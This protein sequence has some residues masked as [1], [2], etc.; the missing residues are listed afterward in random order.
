MLDLLH[1]YFDKEKAAIKAL[2]DYPMMQAVL[3]SAPQALRETATRQLKQATPHTNQ[4]TRTT[5]TIPDPTGNQ[6]AKMIDRE[7]M[8]KNR[9]Q[10][11]A[12]YMEWFLPVW[13][14]LTKQE[15]D[16][17][18]AAY[19]NDTPTGQSIHQ[20]AQATGKNPRTLYRAKSQAVKRLAY[21]LYG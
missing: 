17:L 1:R 8:L 13:A 6:A 21:G 10:Q 12:D 16:L 14:A 15:R 5:T 9:Y 11:A 19:L 7:T 18:E 3:E 2:Q 20:T 4:Q